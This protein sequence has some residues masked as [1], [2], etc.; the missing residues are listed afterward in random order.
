M[1]TEVQRLRLTFP[2]TPQLFQKTHVA[3]KLWSNCRVSWT[4]RDRL[5][6]SH[7]GTTLLPKWHRTSVCGALWPA[8]AE[9]VRLS[10]RS[11]WYGAAEVAVPE[12]VPKAP[13]KAQR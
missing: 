5:Y 11:A 2:S 7:W 8:W 9:A 3:S 13:S 12:S 6:L 1:E 10:G 4:A